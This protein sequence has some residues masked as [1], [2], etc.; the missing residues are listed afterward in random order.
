[1][2]GAALAAVLNELA[3]DIEHL[4]A[5]LCGDAAFVARH[6]TA[7]QAI[8]L[9]AQRQRAVAGLLAADC[10]ACAADAVPLEALRARLVATLGPC[11]C[12][13]MPRAAVIGR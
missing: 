2:S 8:D 6:A 4:G 1:M 5:S 7:L 10:H 9:I 13:H 11:A 3:D 12:G